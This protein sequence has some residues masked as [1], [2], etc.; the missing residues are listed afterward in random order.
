MLT[1]EAFLAENRATGTRRPAPDSSRS[2]RCACKLHSHGEQQ[3]VVAGSGQS[4]IALL[5][6]CL[7]Q[8]MRSTH[9]CRLA[10]S[11]CIT[12][13]LGSQDVCFSHADS[14]CASWLCSLG[15]TAGADCLGLSGFVGPALDACEAYERLRIPHASHKVGLVQPASK[16]PP[17]FHLQLT[18][19]GHRASR[20]VSQD[21]IQ[22]L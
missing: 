21:I 1:P 6:K 3:Q 8:A 11:S 22:R 10:S 14:P 15:S 4:C 16:L 20:G 7:L 9:V 17:R 19:S 2:A 18:G 5:H 12:H 13:S